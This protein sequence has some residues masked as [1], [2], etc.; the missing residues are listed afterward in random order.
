VHFLFASDALSLVGF[1]LVNFAVVF[2]SIVLNDT[3]FH[4]DSAMGNF[5]LQRCL[6]E[7]DCD[8]AGCHEEW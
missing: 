7:M 3:I 5:G 6:A 8:V 4:A 2:I 1:P